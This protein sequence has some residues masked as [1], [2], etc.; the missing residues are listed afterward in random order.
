M[1][2][3]TQKVPRKQ[4]GTVNAATHV[5]QDYNHYQPNPSQKDKIVR[6]NE[7]KDSNRRNVDNTPSWMAGRKRPIFPVDKPRKSP[8]FVINAAC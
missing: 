3:S 2:I 7:D 6:T 4:I 5:Y 1:Y 8:A